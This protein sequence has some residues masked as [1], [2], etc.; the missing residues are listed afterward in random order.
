Y[1]CCDA[2]SALRLYHVIKRAMQALKGRNGVSVWDGY[3]KL[4]YNVQPILTNMQYR[5]SPVNR[6]KML[7]FLQMVIREQKIVSDQLQAVI[8][9]DQR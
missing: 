9:E 8:P 7:S 6:D 4:V 5:G 1:G 2:D 3:C